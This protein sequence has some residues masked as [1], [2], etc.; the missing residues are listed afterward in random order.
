MSI[1]SHVK[2][3]GDFTGIFDRV[4]YKDD[5]ELWNHVTRATYE[6]QKAE[7]DQLVFLCNQTGLS[8][9]DP[10]LTWLDEALEHYYGG[11]L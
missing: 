11:K 9:D 10:K 2:G 4:T 6:N 5:S 3:Y 7:D 1:Y 8:I